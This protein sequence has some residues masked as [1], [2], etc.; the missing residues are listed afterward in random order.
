MNGRDMNVH[1]LQ[2]LAGGSDAGAVTAFIAQAGA[3]QRTVREGGGGGRTDLG[4]GGRSG[5][6]GVA[7]PERRVSV[8]LTSPHAAAAFTGRGVV[9]KTLPPHG[10]DA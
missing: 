8:P 6:A 1:K 9:N 3:P 2:K 7:C 10:R 4:Q 5:G